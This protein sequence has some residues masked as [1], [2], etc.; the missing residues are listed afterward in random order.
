MGLPDFKDERRKARDW[1]DAVKEWRRYIG[2]LFAGMAIAVLLFADVNH[3]ALGVPETWKFLDR[4]AFWVTVGS[5]GAAMSLWMCTK[6]SVARTR[7]ARVDAER[8]VR[9]DMALLKAEIER[10]CRTSKIQQN[11]IDELKRQN[12]DLRIPED[13]EDK[14]TP[15]NPPATPEPDA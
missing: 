1:I 2:F 4:N 3:E 13:H 11:A 10:G 6:Q 12:D 14:E 15:A 9:G 7:A 5:I 8:Q